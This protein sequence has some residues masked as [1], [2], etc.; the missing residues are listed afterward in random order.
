MIGT[1]LKTNQRGQ[2]INVPLRIQQGKKEPGGRHADD[3]DKA[4]LEA[5]IFAAS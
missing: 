4:E 5:G 2:R 1:T 3:P